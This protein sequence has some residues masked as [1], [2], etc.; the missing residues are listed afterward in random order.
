MTRQHAAFVDDGRVLVQDR[1]H[2]G[3]VAPVRGAKQPFQRPLARV[4]AFD[5]SLESDPALVAMLAGERV[6]H[7]A[8][9]RPLRRPGV[10]A[11]ETRACIR[12]A[13]AQ[14]FQPAPGSLPQIVE[15]AHETPP[16]VCRLA[17]A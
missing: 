10:G 3:R 4:L 15:G 12:I 9:R 6:L 17:S 13:L 14:G 7:V 11:H 16:S 5:R 8:K 1:R 2:C